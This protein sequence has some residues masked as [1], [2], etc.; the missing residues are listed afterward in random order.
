MEEWSFEI[1]AH[2]KQESKNV[3]DNQ[4]RGPKAIKRSQG[5]KTIGRVEENQSTKIKAHVG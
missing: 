4:G 2:S 5:Y 1:L 3:F